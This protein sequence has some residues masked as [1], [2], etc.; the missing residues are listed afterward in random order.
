MMESASTVSRL[1]VTPRSIWR[2]R[3]VKWVDGEC[4]EK[5]RAMVATS[6]RS[7]TDHRRKYWRRLG[8]MRLTAWWQKQSLSS[9]LCKRMGWVVYTDGSNRADDI[10]MIYT[11][12]INACDNSAVQCWWF[13]CCCVGQ[14]R[15]GERLKVNREMA[16]SKG[17]RD[18]VTD[19]TASCQRLMN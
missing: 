3:R 5:T 7:V 4:S 10:L 13:W 18:K 6:R 8:M 19:T 15:G 1:M 17:R 11:W 9:R 16:S 2:I 12:W 14:R